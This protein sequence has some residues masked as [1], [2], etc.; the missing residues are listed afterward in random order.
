MTEDFAESIIIPKLTQ[1]LTKMDYIALKKGDVNGDA[2]TNNLI[3]AQPRSTNGNLWINLQDKFV[4]KGE[5][6]EVT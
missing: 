3:A 6:V 4:E 1:D 5:R 2:Q